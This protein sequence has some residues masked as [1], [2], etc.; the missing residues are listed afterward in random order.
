MGYRFIGT[1]IHGNFYQGA[2]P[3]ELFSEVGVR[4]IFLQTLESNFSNFPKFAA[5]RDMLNVHD[6]RPFS[7]ESWLLHLREIDLGYSYCFCS[8]AKSI[9]AG[10]NTMPIAGIVSAFIRWSQSVDFREGS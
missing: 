9:S 6:S 7:L 1:E 2:S 10:S 8:W 3:F 4:P 5:Q